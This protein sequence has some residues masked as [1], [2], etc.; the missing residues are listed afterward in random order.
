LLQGVLE[1]I[2]GVLGP[3]TEVILALT[4]NVFAIGG[5]V[6]LAVYYSTISS[7]GTDQDSI[8]TTTKAL[9]DTS[10]TALTSTEITNM[11]AASTANVGGTKLAEV[12]TARN[13]YATPTC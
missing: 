11:N 9:G 4:A 6:G 3:D 1:P 8:C 13:A 10:I 5:L 7:L 12:I 2:R